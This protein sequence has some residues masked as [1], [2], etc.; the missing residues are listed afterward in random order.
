MELVSIIMPSYNCGRFI[1]EAI[2]SVLAQTYSN[3]ELLIVD[4]C[5]KDE[6]KDIV[7]SYADSRIHYQC[8][9]HNMG[10]AQTRNNALKIAKGRYIAFLD[11]DDL[12]TPDK[13]EKQICFMEQHH[14]AFTFADYQIIQEDGT[15]LNK[16][17]HMP[18]SMTY[19]QYL[20]NTAIGCLTVMIDKEQTGYFEMPDIK[21]SHDMALWLLIMKRG[22]AAHSI[23]ECL[24]SYRIVTTSNTAKKWKAAK[25]VWRVYREIEH[26]NIFH[27]AICFFGYAWHAVIKRL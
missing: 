25:D 11:S 22:F 18:A 13:L 12:W 17:L 1:A 7:G 10:A 14:Y 3:W 23:P 20:R 19:H 2:N 21:S 15:P 9:S 5:S 4:D 27:S 6:T 24:A 16:V 26:L 8:N